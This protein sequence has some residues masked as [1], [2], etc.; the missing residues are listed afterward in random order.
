MNSKS[1]SK[2]A[3]IA[4][5]VIIGGGLHGCSTALHLAMQGISVIVIEKDYV[6]RHASGVNA[7][8]VRR[9]GRDFAEIPLAVESAKMWQKIE[10]LVDS[11]CGFVSSRQ[12]KVAETEEHLEQ[13]KNRVEHVCKM[14]FNHEQIIDQNTLREK[15]PVISDHCVGGLIVEGDGSAN[16]F[17][18]SQAFK[19]KCIS[20]GVQIKEKVEVLNI[21]KN[22][23][24]WKIST[25]KG[26]FEAPIFVNSSGAWG[27]KIAETLGEPVPIEARAPMLMITNR[28]PHFIDAVVGVQGKPLSFKQFQN[29][30]VMIGGGHVGTANT[31]TN[32][33]QLND[34][35]LA[36]NASIAISLFPIIRNARVVRSWAGIE[37]YL[38]DNI[39]VISKSNI[40]GAFHSFGYSAHGFQLAP[41]AGKIL[42]ELIID[43]KSELPIEPF[44]INRFS[45]TSYTSAKIQ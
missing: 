28:L 23:N 13:L 29:G 33:T 11:D 15:V 12:I 3:N 43:G 4:D 1:T 6:G 27:G 38:P 21:K 26:Q 41:I 7:G 24:I 18:T 35:G 5:V 10:S 16:P 2:N 17:R 20:L 39:P 32:E 31:A 36:I 34:K 9:L 37:G 14:G 25:S 45:S 19:K 40:D 8:G 42:S 22:G 44:N 30:T